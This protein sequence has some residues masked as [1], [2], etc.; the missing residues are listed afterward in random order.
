[1]ATAQAAL[2]DGPILTA[3]GTPLKVSLQKSLVRSKMRAVA[4][5]APPLLFLLILFIIP[6]GSMLTRSID[7]ALVNKVFPTTLEAFEAW[8]KTS[9]PPEVLYE[10]FF[11]DVVAAEKLDVGKVG[12]RMNY[13]KPGWKSLIKR[14]ARKL[15]NIKSGPYKE[16]LIKID[17]RWED[18]GFWLSLGIM[19]D[20][21]TMVYFLNSID[22]TFDFDKNIISVEENRQVY[23]LL[24]RRT[25]MVSFI[26]TNN[27][28]KKCFQLHWKPS[29]PGTRP[30]SHRKYS[31]NHFLMTLLLPKNS[32]SV[33]LERV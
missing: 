15:K 27:V 30:P 26:V 7:D 33:R 16:A 25:L 24:W 18:K 4:L 21:R 17:K 6:I 29:K 19:K 32:M 23:N 1:M 10:S 3:D 28:I 2:P 8:D 13:A 12:T 5:V 20:E 11:N 14:T 22:K 9:E 31:T